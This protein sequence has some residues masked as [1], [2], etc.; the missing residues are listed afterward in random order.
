MAGGQDFRPLP[1]VWTA[2]ARSPLGG[3]AAA[4]CGSRSCQP[5]DLVHPSFLSLHP[6]QGTRQGI[7]N[8]SGDWRSSSPEHIQ[9]NTGDQLTSGRVAV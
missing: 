2:G 3:G 7:R 6:S 9:N 1:Q 5:A 4:S 8:R